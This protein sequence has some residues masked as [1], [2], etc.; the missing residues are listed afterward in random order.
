MDKKF[1]IKYQQ[2]KITED[3]LNRRIFNAFNIL[4]QNEGLYQNLNNKNDYENN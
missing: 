1:E 2:I 4:F 3:E